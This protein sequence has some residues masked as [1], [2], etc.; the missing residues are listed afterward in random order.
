MALPTEQMSMKDLLK[1]KIFVINF[2]LL[3][4]AKEKLPYLDVGIGGVAGSFPQDLSVTIL[5]K[6]TAFSPNQ[7][8]PV[9]SVYF[10]LAGKL[11]QVMSIHLKTSKRLTKRP[12]P[13]SIEDL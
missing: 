9:P 6:F 1:N 11:S 12:R 8:V 10:L 7:F 3:L 2:L 4:G 13:K 5:P